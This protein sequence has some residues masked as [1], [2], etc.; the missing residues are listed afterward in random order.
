MNKTKDITNNPATFYS[1]NLTIRYCP[2]TYTGQE[3]VKLLYTPR[4]IT[5]EYPDTLL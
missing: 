4:N 1:A 3:Y 5:W 2:L